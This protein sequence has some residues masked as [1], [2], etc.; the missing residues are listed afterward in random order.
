MNDDEIKKKLTPEEYRILREQGTE[1]PFSGEYVNNHASGVYKC[2]V[3]GTELF[4]SGTK[5]DSG[6]G[7]P[8]FTDPANTKHVKLIEDTTGG[9]SR[10]EVRCANCDS[11]LGHVFNDG[12]RSMPDGKP[13]SG[14]R[15]CINSACLDFEEKEGLHSN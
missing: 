3:C 8:S 6:T 7:W 2:K 14:S 5:F 12:P 10:V 15:Y 11:H 9:M 13:A 4:M 1:V